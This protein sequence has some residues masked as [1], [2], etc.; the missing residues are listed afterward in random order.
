MSKDYSAVKGSQGVGGVTLK[1][2]K[3]FNNAYFEVTDKGMVNDCCH[4][5]IGVFVDQSK[6]EK[7]TNIAVSFDCEGDQTNLDQ[8][9][10]DKAYNM[11]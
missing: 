10:L 1:A 8:R 9:C 11:C 4:A 3:V 5:N 7:I 6:A 2:D